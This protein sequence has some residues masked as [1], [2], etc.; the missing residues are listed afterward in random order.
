MRVQLGGGDCTFD[1][2]NFL[3]MK[4][5]S[6]FSLLFFLIGIVF[7]PVHSYAQNNPIKSVDVRI[8][9]EYLVVVGHFTGLINAEMKETLA[10]GMSGMLHFQSKLINSR[11]GVIS[12]IEQN[13]LLRYNVWEKMYSL[14][15]AK[16]ENE[17]KDFKEFEQFINDS[18]VFDVSFVKRLPP[19]KKIQ[20]ILSFSPEKISASQK[21]KLNDW[22]KSEGEINESKPALETESTFSI[23]L[24][25]LISIFLKKKDDDRLYIYRSTPFTIQSL[26][27]R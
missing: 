10:S 8:D 12:E 9:N 16:T 18:L 27:K 22:L 1:A 19:D 15:S 24:S 11:S 21:S 26:Q 13:I 23:N 6:N 17:F 2:R 3:I 7:F 4:K 20:I 25:N 14:H 5:R